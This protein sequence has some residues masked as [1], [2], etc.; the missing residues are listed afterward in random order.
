MRL[1]P[2]LLCALLAQQVSAADISLGFNTPQVNENRTIDEIYQAALAEGGI[3][4]CWHG[5]DE[6]TQQDG[7]KRAFETRFPGMTLNITVNRSKYHSVNVDRQLA[8]GRPLEVDTIILQA[9]QDYTRWEQQGSLLHYA[10][11]N[12]LKVL[13]PFRHVRAA[14]Y[15]F[16]M[17]AW[18]TVWNTQKLAN[19]PREWPD[20]LKPEYRGKIVLTHPSDD[21]A[22]AYIFDLVMH[23]YGPEWF[24]GLLANEPRWV[25]GTGS[26]LAVLRQ[27][28]STQSVTFTASIGLRSSGS[29]NASFPTE[30]L[31]V[32]WPRSVAIFKDAPHPEASKLFANF[33]LDDGFQ[34]NSSQWSARKDIT[35]P[36]GYPGILDM[37]TTNSAEYLRFMSDRGRVEALRMMFEDKIGMPQGPSPLVDDL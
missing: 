4:T 9:L 21:D 10:P 32:S 7:L 18:S 2:P 30:G 26:P 24:D 15:G 20:F 28:N 1:S 11:N 17:N 22:I 35:A 8:S 13:A 37:D 25:R 23:Q 5:G 12:Y 14:Y 27:P 29:L 34:R 19:P 3:V 31:F 36:G 16:A 33:L 6:V